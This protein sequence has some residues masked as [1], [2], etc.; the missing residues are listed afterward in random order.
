MNTR[1]RSRRVVGRIF[2]VFALFFSVYSCS[3]VEIRG[4]LAPAQKPQVLASHTDNV[5][6]VA[7][8]PG[9][10]LLAT[11]SSDKSVRLWDPADPDR[12]R[13]LSG[14]TSDVYR[15]AFSADGR[16]LATASQD[17]TA[18]LWDMAG[19]KAAAVLKGHGDPV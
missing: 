1:Y 19:G 17:K 2:P 5:Y 14:H 6:S 4:S 11:A 10:A 7:F 9:G 12:P 8:A 15:C 3:F 18:R 13:V 16:L